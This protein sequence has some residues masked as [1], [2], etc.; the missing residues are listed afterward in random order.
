MSSLSAPVK[1]AMTQPVTVYNG[2][3]P[4]TDVA[5]ELLA[6][7]IGSVVITAP[8]R[9]IVTKTDLVAGLTDDAFDPGQPVH[10]LMTPDPV[11][12]EE[13]T[14][15]E[16]AIETMHSH[17]IKRLPVVDATD[18]IV[19]IVT[20]SDLLTVLTE[21]SESALGSLATALSALETAPPHRYECPECTQQVT[22]EEQPGTCPD[23]GATMHN[24]SVPRE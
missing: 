19:G 1:T 21:D 23:C 22:A 20:T 14:S 3:R 2:T 24:I 15:I 12:V 16:T 18:T 4:V 17:G 10:E 13:T 9:G 7:E 5:T 11:T 8:E 6:G